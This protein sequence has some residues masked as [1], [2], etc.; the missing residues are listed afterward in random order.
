MNRVAPGTVG[1]ATDLPPT[2]AVAFGGKIH[3][4][5]SAEKIIIGGA[6]ARRHLET[7]EDATRSRPVA[8]RAEIRR[9]LHFGCFL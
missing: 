1:A 2:W 6:V 7:V 5:F 9:G 3:T 4:L 8:A